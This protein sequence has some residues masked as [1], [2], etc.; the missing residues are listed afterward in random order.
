MKTK[1]PRV[2]R[3]TRPLKR[4]VRRWYR[5]EF[6]TGV[7]WSDEGAYPV[8]TWGRNHI[9]TLKEARADLEDWKRDRGLFAANII[10]HEELDSIVVKY[11]PNNKLSGGEQT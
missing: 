7:G 1:K 9:P 10:C 8:M 5:T 11:K 6:E 4:L 2:K 3:P